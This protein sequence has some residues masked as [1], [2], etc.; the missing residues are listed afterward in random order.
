MK[1]VEGILRFLLKP[2]AL[3]GEQLEPK[4]V[5]QKL[6]RLA[7]GRLADLQ[8]FRRSRVAQP[9][10]GGLEDEQVVGGWY[11]KAQ[12]RT[13]FSQPALSSTATVGAGW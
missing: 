10:R 12:P 2:P 6:D 3:P 9:P 4:S 5:V 1:M 8:F 7:D 13:S 11:G